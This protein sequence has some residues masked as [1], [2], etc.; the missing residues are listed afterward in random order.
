MIVPLLLAL[1]LV[2]SMAKL[3]GIASTRIG[4]PAVLGG[5][6][7]GLLLGPSVLNVFGI[8]YFESVHV[9]ETLHTLG[10]LGVIFLMFVA[11]LETQLSDLV[12]T[13]KPAALTGTSGVIVPII[14]G[15]VAVLAFGYSLSQAIFVGIVLS[16]T[17]VSISAQTLMELGKLRSREGMTLLGAAVVD[18]V[19][20][21]IVFSGFIAISQGGAG[22]LTS[23]IWIVVRIA[24]YLVGASVL[25]IWLLP[26][27]VRWVEKVPVSA[28]VTNL[29]IVSFLIFAWAAEAIGGVAAITGAFIAGV[30]L[31][32]STLKHQIEHNI[33][34]MAYSFFV[35]IFLVSIGL[36]ADISSLSINDYGLAAVICVVAI[37]SKVVGAGFGAKLGN[38][39]WKESLRVGVGMISRGEVG[40]ILAG[41]GLRTTHVIS[42]NI[43]TVVVLMVLVTTIVT[44]PLLRWA[45]TEKENEKETQYA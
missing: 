2:I 36:S 21:I 43:F 17:S 30:A 26:R 32:G 9:S 27:A 25:G 23:L 20:A 39:S 34:P 12:K 29:V 15:A 16:A 40:L 8:H 24:I 6:V 33:H 22:N 44:P 45:F 14:L 41:I 7:V 18:D 3:G 28:P 37:V 42:D 5:L 13:G 11:G 10:E 38:M 4:Q 1:A 35:P 31:S 19:L